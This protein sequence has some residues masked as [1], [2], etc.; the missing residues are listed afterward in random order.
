MVTLMLNE[1]DTVGHTFKKAFY[2]VDGVTMYVFWAIWIAIWIW[3]LFDPNQPSIAALLC[4][5]VGMVNPFLFILFGL[6]R[7]PGLLT[8]FLIIGLNVRALLALV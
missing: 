8:A 6:M 5:V 2:R 1:T 3:I 7:F 4:F